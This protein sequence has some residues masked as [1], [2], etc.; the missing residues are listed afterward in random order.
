MGIDFYMAKSKDKINFENI[1]IELHE[2][3]FEIIRNL[4]RR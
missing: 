3:F 4:R 2:N 1:A